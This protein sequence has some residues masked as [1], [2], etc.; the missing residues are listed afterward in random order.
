MRAIEGPSAECYMLL[1]ISSLLQKRIDTDETFTEDDLHAIWI[2]YQNLFT[3]WDIVFEAGGG[4]PPI[5]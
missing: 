4:P 5:H 1:R 3:F 2:S